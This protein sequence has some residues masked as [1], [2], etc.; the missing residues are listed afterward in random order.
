MTGLSGGAGEQQLI[1][2]MVKQ[3]ER[4]NGDMKNVNYVQIVDRNTGNVVAKQRLA[5]VSRVS[6]NTGRGDDWVTIKAD[7]F[8]DLSDGEAVPEFLVDTGEGDQDRLEIT[9]G[10]DLKWSVR[11]ADAG[12]VSGNLADGE[13][14]LNVSWSGAEN[15]VGGVGKD[16]LAVVKSDFT[17]VA[18]SHRPAVEGPGARETVQLNGASLSYSDFDSVESTWVIDRSDQEAAQRL[19]VKRVDGENGSARFAAVDADDPAVVVAATSASDTTSIILRTGDGDDRIVIDATSFGAR[20]SD[21]PQ[22]PV[23]IVDA[24]RGQDQLV[25]TNDAKTDWIVE[26][27]GDGVAWA[28]VAEDSGPLT[29]DFTGVESL[30]G[31]GPTDSLRIKHVAGPAIGPVIARANF[32][33]TEREINLGA[34]ENEDE[35]DRIVQ[36]KLVAVETT[37]NEETRTAYYVKVYDFPTLDSDPEEIHSWDLSDISILRV[38]LGGGANNRVVIDATSFASLL[39]KNAATRTPS[40]IVTGEKGAN[41]VLTVLS[42]ENSRW[43]LSG[44]GAGAGDVSS[45]LDGKEE[46][47]RIGFT[48]IERLNGGNGEDTLAY[49][50]T[51]YELIEMSGSPES[52]SVTLD[53]ITVSYTDFELVESIYTVD[54]SSETGDLDLRFKLATDPDGA[55]RI[56]LVD[57]SDRELADV[58]LGAV[59]RF[60]ILTGSGDD[61]VTIDADGFDDALSISETVNPLPII[62]FDGGEGNDRIAILNDEATLWTL[63]D[64]GESGRMLATLDSYSEALLARFTSVEELGGGSGEDT[65]LGDAGDRA[66]SVT[67]A[68]AARVGPALDAQ[69]R[70]TAATW[71]LHGFEKLAAGS[72]KNWFVGKNEDTTWTFSTDG[73]FEVYGFKAYGMRGIR[74]GGAID[75]IQGPGVNVVWTL[76][77]SNSGNLRFGAGEDGRM[78][79]VD[80]TGVERLRGGHNVDQFVLL[81]NA[82][83]S[84]DLDGGEGGTDVLIVR[85]SLFDSVSW[86]D[87]LLSAGAVTLTHKGQSS[88]ISWSGLE[89]PTYSIVGGEARIV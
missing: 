84:G 39:G 38:T 64:S 3:R 69:D 41:D 71:T 61:T 76:D 72:G 29:V 27:D 65:A 68:G 2:K 5:D 1:V 12:A 21:S 53:D 25:I 9:H 34:E 22:P 4:A 7:S 11:N 86:R 88:V 47:L 26:P 48:G 33:S 56:K 16:E 75:A 36:V 40:F 6:V 58:E 15:L 60:V 31:A 80:F 85:D 55:H 77:G 43:T 23:I 57:G 46:G 51:D 10:G 78:W 70:A 62:E 87:R 89:R 66:W 49:E 30:D 45:A 67:E 63:P 35:E 37:V 14:R 83:L 32:E 42:D 52:G 54:R 44:A 20:Q 73:S 13:T 81:A 8:Q 59:T 18:F 19:L 28:T 82:A 74:A 50:Y 17:S 24:G 79:T